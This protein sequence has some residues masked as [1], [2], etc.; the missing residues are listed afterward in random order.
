MLSD[1]A[2]ARQA[3]PRVVQ[4]LGDELHWSR[5]RRRGELQDGQRFLDTFQP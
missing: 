5:A 3:L 2:L 1:A 4:I